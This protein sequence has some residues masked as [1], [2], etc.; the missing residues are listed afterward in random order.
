M[1][2]VLLTAI[3]LRSEEK[4]LN[5][6]LTCTDCNTVSV[7]YVYFSLLILFI[8]I[9]LA[10]LKHWAGQE[11]PSSKLATSAVDRLGVRSKKFTV[12]LTTFLVSQY[13]SLTDYVCSET[14]KACVRDHAWFIMMA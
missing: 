11:V 14:N 6:F 4:T 13:I 7:T 3:C 5:K 8:S 10:L 2:K 9:C 12:R 1:L